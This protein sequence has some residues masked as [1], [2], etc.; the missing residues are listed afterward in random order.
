MP[1]IGTA[2]AHDL[3][4]CYKALLKHRE[5]LCRLMSF[6]YMCH[7]TTPRSIWQTSWMGL[8]MFLLPT[9]N[10]RL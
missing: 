1:Q 8:G 3:L 9:L 6:V 10:N 4:H 7:L 2:A 5:G